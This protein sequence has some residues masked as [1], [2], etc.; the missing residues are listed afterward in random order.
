[1]IK[2]KLGQR[3]NFKNGCKSAINLYIFNNSSKVGNRICMLAITGERVWETGYNVLKF[4]PSKR[5]FIFWKFVR[6]QSIL[7]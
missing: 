7:N 5:Q 2:T 3:I 4:A 6:D 1:M